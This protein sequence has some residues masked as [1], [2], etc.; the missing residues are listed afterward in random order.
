MHADHADMTAGA[1]HVDRVEQRGNNADALEDRVDAAAVG[2][3][4]DVTGHVTVTR[5]DRHGAERLRHLET[6]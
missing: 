2:V 5:V 6:L 3:V 1:H 4:L